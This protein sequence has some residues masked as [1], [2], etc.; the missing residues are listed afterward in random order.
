[1]IGVDL[2]TVGIE[3]VKRRAN[4][5]KLHISLEVADIYNYIIPPG[6]DI[7]LMD[8]MLHFYKNN[9]QKETEL[10]NSLL[11]QLKNGGFFCNCLLKGKRREMILKDIIEKSRF[12]WNIIYDD[13]IDYP[14]N[15]SE[16]HFLVLEKRWT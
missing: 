16:Y 4:Q 14:D 13:Y 10:V 3:Q 11:D 5:L 1:M 15:N 6:V 7:I 2:S 9:I 12:E 8:S